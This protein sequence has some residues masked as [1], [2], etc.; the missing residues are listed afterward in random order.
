MSVARIVAGAKFYGCN[1]ECLQL[2][3]HGW[4]RK[5]R[6][7]RRENSYAHN[8]PVCEVMKKELEHEI[9]LRN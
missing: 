4:K 8:D 5:L 9:S 1:L 3:E 2:L 7:E 6:E